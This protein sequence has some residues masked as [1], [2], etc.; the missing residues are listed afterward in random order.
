M[1]FLLGL[2]IL[3]LLPLLHA[4][5]GLSLIPGLGI[6]K[7][8]ALGLSRGSRGLGWGS[9]TVS[10]PGLQVELGP[11]SGLAL[12]LIARGPLL[13]LLP[14]LPLLPL[15]VPGPVALVSGAVPGALPGTIPR[16]LPVR[17]PAVLV[18]P[19]WLNAG[20]TVGPPVVVRLAPA[21]LL[22]VFGLPRITTG[23][24]P[25]ARAGGRGPPVVR[26]VGYKGL[27]GVGRADNKKG[28]TRKRK[29]HHAHWGHQRGQHGLSGR[30]GRLRSG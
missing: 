1:L 25:R 18:L 7:R 12:L 29:T 2:L 21:G 14:G 23:V 5:L 10:R 30:G 3:L 19:G 15:T 11:H 22:G 20:V 27:D 16:S 17:A 28:K 8:V 26:A 9:R 4:P 24:V 13:P 6:T